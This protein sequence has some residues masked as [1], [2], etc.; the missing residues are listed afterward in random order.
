MTPLSEWQ[1][2]YLHTANLQNVT[3]GF[4][5]PAGHPMSPLPLA[6]PPM[7]WGPEFGGGTPTVMGAAR[8]PYL[9]PRYPMEVVVSTPIA[10]SLGAPP[11]LYNVHDMKLLDQA[12]PPQNGV[13]E[14]MVSGVTELGD[15]FAYRLSIPN[16][17]PEEWM[18]PANSYLMV[19]P[20][21]QPQ[22]QAAGG[23]GDV[24][25]VDTVLQA[26]SVTEQLLRDC[27]PDRAAEVLKTALALLGRPP[28]V[29]KIVPGIAAILCADTGAGLPSVKLVHPDEFKNPSTF[30]K[31]YGDPLCF[32]KNGPLP[33]KGRNG[34]WECSK[35]T[36]VNFPR[37]FRCNMCGTGRGEEGDWIVAEYARQVYERYLYIYKQQRPE[38]AAPEMPP[39]QRQPSNLRSAQLPAHM[40]PNG[41]QDGGALLEYPPAHRAHVGN[42]MASAHAGRRTGGGPAYGAPR[43]GSFQRQAYGDQS[44]LLHE[45]PRQPGYAGFQ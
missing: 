31:I 4:L 44:P 15:D 17:P 28:S 29:G 38:A 13:N 37:R 14:Q 1:Q 45:V 19:M 16:Q 35:C 7:M 6:A 11:D 20:P 42:R 26:K 40:N 30:L 23:K 2:Q 36:N 32:A 34:N 27:N 22:Q 3:T 10:Q 5:S 18:A 21:Q 9:S 25:L 41:I 8:S 24:R 39:T 12:D 43:Y 33:K